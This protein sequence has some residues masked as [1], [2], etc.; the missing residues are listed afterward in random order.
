MK[1]LRLLCTDL[2]R[3]LIPNGKQEELPG[4]RQRFAKLID[5]NAIHLAFVSGRDHKL[6]DAAIQEYHLPT[7]DYV[8]ADVGSSIYQCHANEW[9]LM[10]TWHQQISQDWGGR[11]SGELSE[12]FR[13][14]PDLMMQEASK[15]GRFKLSY[16]LSL[17][18][19]P[20]EIC[21]QI[22][23][24]AQQQQVSISLIYS[25]DEQ[26][27]IGLLDILPA[28]ANKREAIGYLAERLAINL[29]E[30][31][32]AGDS[33]NDLEVLASGVPSVLVAN[34]MDSVKQ[35]AINMAERAGNSDTLYLA[36]GVNGNGNY[37]DG[38]MEGIQHFFP[39][40]QT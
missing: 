32:F 7:P 20:T 30:V 1:S 6:V 27:Q 31:L 14:I 25:V 4:S 26:K 9:A 21:T 3:T 36:H 29:N 10:E 34:A 40:L 15:Q 35:D 11:T 28:S 22:K 33:G 17:D 24:Q 38:I 12:Y 19:D 23:T 8:I 18:V 2:D 5:E 37:A 13:N 39:E 16:Y